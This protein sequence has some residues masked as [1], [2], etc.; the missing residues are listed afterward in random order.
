MLEINMLPIPSHTALAL[1]KQEAPLVRSS[2]KM[3]TN[4]CANTPTTKHQ[5]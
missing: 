1:S 4:F 2:F 3:P 5:K